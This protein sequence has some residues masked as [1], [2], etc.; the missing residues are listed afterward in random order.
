MTA[1][2]ESAKSDENK[3]SSF[4]TRRRGIPPRLFI[5]EHFDPIWALRRSRNRASLDNV[6]STVADFDR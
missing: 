1:R 4:D 5:F 3:S 2:G 6:A